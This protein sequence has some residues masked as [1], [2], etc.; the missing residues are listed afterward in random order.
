MKHILAMLR[1]FQ[2]FSEF[3]S[4]SCITH[5]RLFLPHFEN[6]ANLEAFRTLLCIAQ[7]FQQLCSGSLNLQRMSESMFSLVKWRLCICAKWIW[8]NRQKVI[9][10][11]PDKAKQVSYCTCNART[12]YLSQRGHPFMLA[13]FRGGSWNSDVNK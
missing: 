13:E 11:I 10:W 5:Y 3:L 4:N 8:K 6:W 9:A 2:Q 1:L 12:F 7:F